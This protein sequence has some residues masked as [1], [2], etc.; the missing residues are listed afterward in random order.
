VRSMARVEERIHIHR[1]VDRVW[2]LLI[3]WESQPQWMQDAKTVTVT[4]AHRSGVGVTIDVPTN[5]ALGITVLD[6]MEV[7]EWEEGRKIAVRHTGK[8][9]KGHGAFEIAPSVLPDG[10]EGTIFTWWEQI[11]APLGR[12]GD[13]IARYTAVPIVSFVFRRS[14]RALKAYAEERIPA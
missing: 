11:D 1:P 13:L 10:A 2:S 8:V 12:V 7:T 5:I 14:L 9:I 4:S 6:V 3:D